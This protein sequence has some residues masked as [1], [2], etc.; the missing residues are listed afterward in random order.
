MPLTSPIAHLT[1]A[2]QLI[3]SKPLRP[4]VL[5][6]LLINL[7][8]FIVLTTLLV[9]GFEGAIDWLLGMLPGWMSFVSGILWGL[10]A[11][12]LVVVYGY[13]F[14]MITNIV[15]APFYGT[16]A[17]RAEAQITGKAPAD[18]PLRQMIPRTLRR[19]MV[20]LFYFLC[21]G[22]SIMVLCLILSFIPLLNLLVPVIGVAWGAWSMAIQ[23]VDYS[24]D[25]HQLSFAELRRRLREHAY[26]S[27]GTG[28][29]VMLGTMVPILNILIMPV[30]VVAGTSFWC[31]QLTRVKYPN[32]TAPNP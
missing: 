18:E 14:S 2:S 12:I 32:T 5:V 4:F 19:E 27:Y 24:A 21:W 9:Q 16:L 6:P 17:A 25:N 8:L 11:I 22:S 10:F 15:A 28:G 29:L 31:E 30:A 13:S 26:T 23:Y 3:I 20:K 7:L 1:R